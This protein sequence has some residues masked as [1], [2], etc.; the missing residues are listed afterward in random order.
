MA[1]IK[2]KVALKNVALVIPNSNYSNYY[3]PT[4]AFSLFCSSGASSSGIFAQD[5]GYPTVLTIPAT[6]GNFNR[7]LG[8]KTYELANHLGNVQVTMN[9]KKL[10]VPNPSNT[11]MAQNY[12]PDVVSQTD[13]YAFGSNMSS[14]TT[15]GFYRYGFNGMEKVDEVNNLPGTSY[16]ANFWQY[17]PRLGRRWNID[18]ISYPW[19]SP[20]QV[21]DDCP[22]SI[23]DP[24]GL[25]SGPD[26]RKRHYRRGKFREH[27]KSLGHYFMKS[28]GFVRHTFTGATANRELIP[29]GRR[30]TSTI[31]IGGNASPGENSKIENIRKQIDDKIIAEGGGRN[32]TD[33]TG[34]TGVFSNGDAVYNK[35]TGNWDYKGHIGGYAYAEGAG[36]EVGWTRLSLNT[37]IKGLKQGDDDEDDPPIGGILVGS[38]FLPGLGFVDDLLGHFLAGLDA[39]EDA[40]RFF[41]PRRFHHLNLIR[42]TNSKFTKHSVRYDLVV[43]YRYWRAIPFNSRSQLFKNLHKE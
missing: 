7:W 4:L 23:D 8:D 25:A 42:V 3:E 2:N 5:G 33:I 14:R 13:Y 20:Y 18:P 31:E 35:E 29:A 26:F 10:P 41:V 30:F 15:G 1:R 39:I 9:D 43:R 36:A 19:L 11:G 22:I 17:D 6:I 34:I 28:A 12:M 37:G 40:N 32:N 16:T 21:F 24:E 38:E 27:G